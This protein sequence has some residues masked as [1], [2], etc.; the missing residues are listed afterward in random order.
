[1][2][3]KI[4]VQKTLNDLVYQDLKRKILTG[5]IPSRTRLMEI[6][7]A[8][9]M[10]VSRTPIREAIRRLAED[11]L[12]QVEPRRGAF[13]S[14]ISIKDMLDVFE[15]RADLEGFTAYLAAQRIT[16]EQ[17]AEQKYWDDIRFPFGKTSEDVFAI[18][19]LMS[20]TS[21][22]RIGSF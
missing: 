3:F 16:E 18:Y 21:Q 12:V 6:E 9:K 7:L 2:E 5:E 13:V 11:G 14:N 17:K 4:K 20:F 15:T 10:N 19:L 22:V 1:M 8:N